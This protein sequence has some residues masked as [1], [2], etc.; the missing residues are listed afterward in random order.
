MGIII[1]N[2]NATTGITNI[3]IGSGEETQ[4][5]TPFSFDAN[6]LNMNNSIS[7]I[8]LGDGSS[9]SYFTG[10]Y[11]LIE[12]LGDFKY[13]QCDNVNIY[14]DCDD[15]ILRG[16]KFRSKSH[17]FIP[18]A[19]TAYSHYHNSTNLSDRL[20]FGGNSHHTENI[21][22]WNNTQRPRLNSNSVVHIGKWCEIMWTHDNG[23][24]RF[25]VDGVQRFS[26]NWTIQNYSLVSKHIRTFWGSGNMLK[27]YQ[28]QIE[29]LNW[30]G[31]FNEEW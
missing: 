18:N 7:D 26:G 1:R 8:I 10:S 11:E 4:I 16:K 28:I 5:I 2:M 9:E 27:S 30:E 3:R 14:F 31:D 23:T 12:D 20:A 24:W 22:M 21:T 15:P 13:I 17:Q 25:F 6:L 29:N 19:S